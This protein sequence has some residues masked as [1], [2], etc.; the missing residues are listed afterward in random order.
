MT[1]TVF[2]H[3]KQGGIINRNAVAQAFK[4]LHDGSY[5]CTIEHSKR[6]TNLQNAYFHAVVVPLVY[7]GLRAVGFSDVKNNEDAKTVIKTL[8][9]K[10]KIRN[11]KTEDIIEV[12][13]GTHELTTIEMNEFLEEVA[14][15]AS[16]YLGIYI[17]APGEQTKINY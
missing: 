15:W 16:E 12:V 3:I 10:R 7:Q 5:I 11:E 6:R 13:R 2:V 17:P 4:Q 9:L 1:S 14:R 8:F